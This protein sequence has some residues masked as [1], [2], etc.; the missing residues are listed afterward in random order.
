MHIAQI[1]PTSSELLASLNER[2][3]RARL[4]MPWAEGQPAVAA[5]PTHGS[6]S[7][8]FTDILQKVNELQ[9]EADHQAELVAT[10]RAQDLHSAV[11]AVEKAS[12]A[13]QLTMQV[14]R[15]AIEAYQEIS[16]MQL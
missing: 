12:L 1:P 13:L 5:E 11:L 16:R 7:D 6:F 15:R 4:N 8:I 3:E 14:T 9:L 2:V 10:G